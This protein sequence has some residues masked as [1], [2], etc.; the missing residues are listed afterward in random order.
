MSEFFGFFL[1]YLL[2][3]PRHNKTNKMSVGPAKTQI[4][5]G[6]RPGWSESSLCAKWVAKDPSFLHADSKDT[7]QTGQMPRLIWVFVRRTF[8]LLVLS[9]HGSYGL[10]I[11]QHWDEI[12]NS[13]I[14]WASSWEKLS[15]GFPTRVDSNQPAQLQRPASVLK[16]W[17]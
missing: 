9:C 1:W 6:I 7:D 15:S 16:L 10:R 17:V 13:C 3:E 2:Y 4:S 12:A 14:I 11:T 8:T 5:L